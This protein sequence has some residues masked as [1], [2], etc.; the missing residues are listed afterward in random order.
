MLVATCDRNRNFRL[1]LCSLCPL[2]LCVGS[3]AL[4]ASTMRSR[5]LLQILMHQSNRHAALAD[6]RRD[7]FD[8]TQAH[9]TA[10]EDTGNTR[11]EAIGIPVLRPAT[12]LHR[13]V[14]G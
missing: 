5:T 6:C 10:G 1:S 14:A 4:A 9:I 7:A 12:G 2:C 11:F 13:I 8:G 3:N